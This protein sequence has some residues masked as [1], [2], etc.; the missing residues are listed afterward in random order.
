GDPG[1]RTPPAA[2]PPGPRPPGRERAPGPPGPRPARR[3]RESRAHPPRRRGPAEPGAPPERPAEQRSPRPAVLP[4]GTRAPGAE[5][6]AALP[7]G[8]PSLAEAREPEQDRGAQ[9]R[10]RPARSRLRLGA[11]G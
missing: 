6:L 1:W 5:G 10:H 8:G 11:T 4:A 9:R 3:W 7:G 2:P